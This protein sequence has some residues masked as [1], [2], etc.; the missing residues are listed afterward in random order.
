MSGM[1]KE[2]IHLL[3]SCGHVG[4]TFAIA[5]VIGFAGG[6]WLDRKFFDGA[7]S[8][9][10]TFIGLGFGIAAGYKTLF[11]VVRVVRADERRRTPRHEE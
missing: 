9:W 8:P 7:T 6:V 10:F 5:V 11:D 1:K 4:F 2:F 3:A